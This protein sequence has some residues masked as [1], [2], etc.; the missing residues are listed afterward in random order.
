MYQCQ[1]LV[2]AMLQKEAELCNMQE[3]LIKLWNILLLMLR[4]P[5]RP[6]CH[7]IMVM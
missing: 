1:V 6:L 3:V 7:I 4:K 5:A 2:Q